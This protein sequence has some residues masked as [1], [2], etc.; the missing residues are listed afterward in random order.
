METLQNSLHIASSNNLEIEKTISILKEKIVLL[1]STIASNNIEIKRNIVEIKKRD[2][3]IKSR[4][5]E[6]EKRD[7]EIEK[8]DI[9]IQD[10]EFEK[11]QYKKLLFGR[12]T[13]KLKYLS[14][15]QLLLPL[16]DDLD[17]LDEQ[18]EEKAE[19]RLSEELQLIRKEQER[20]EL[21]YYFNFV[22]DL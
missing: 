9:R 6:I 15:K 12:K 19:A 14:K 18:E 21:L 7:A 8:R 3:E 2:I 5:V 17:L 22:I 16:F 10:K 1:N 13:E 4:D 11:A 20:L